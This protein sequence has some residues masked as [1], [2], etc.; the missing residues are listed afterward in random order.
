[1]MKKIVLLILAFSVLASTAE[2]TYTSTLAK[3]SRRGQSFSFETFNANICW[4]ATYLSPE[5]RKAR[6]LK[7]ADLMG[8]G[9][10]ETDVAMERENT[11]VANGT[12]FFVSLYAPKGAREFR[13]DDK[14][15][16]TI[17]L[18]TSSGEAYAPVSI[19]KQPSDIWHKVFYNYNNPWSVSYMV[20]FPV[21]ALGKDFDLEMR[22]V[23]GKSN[24]HWKL[25]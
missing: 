10:E 1:M 24:I 8:W 23:I 15:N 3:W 13:L 18:V 20:T 14:T 21:V 17:T 5:F 4:Y 2:A 22:S 7:E 9:D 6:V 16:W 25:K 19:E 11:Q 12:Q